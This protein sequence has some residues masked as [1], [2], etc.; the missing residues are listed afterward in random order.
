MHLIEISVTHI[1]TQYPSKSVTL[2]TQENRTITTSRLMMAQKHIQ[3]PE[4]TAL[5]FPGQSSKQA[6]KHLDVQLTAT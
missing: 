6:I 1:S 5:K 2:D 4:V 3:S